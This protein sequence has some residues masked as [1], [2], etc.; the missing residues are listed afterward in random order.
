M[1]VERKLEN[2]FKTIQHGH[3]KN[4][5]VSRFDPYQSPKFLVNLCIKASDD[6][7]GLALSAFGAS[8]AVLHSFRIAVSISRKDLI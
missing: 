8:N 6:V 7:T 5:L 2:A 1:E 3:V 4:P